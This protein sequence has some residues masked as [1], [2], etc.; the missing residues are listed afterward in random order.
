MRGI[1][2]KADRNAQILAAHRAGKSYRA[3][4][5]EHA[6]SIARVFAIVAREKKRVFTLSDAADAVKPAHSSES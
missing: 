2:E 4:A 1:P 6:V 5:R 3:I